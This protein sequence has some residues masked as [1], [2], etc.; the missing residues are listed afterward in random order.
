ML[1]MIKLSERFFQEGSLKLC[2]MAILCLLP[3]SNFAQVDKHSNDKNNNIYIEH[4]DVLSFDEKANP[5]VQVLMGN[6]IFRH[7]SS[8]MYC[9]SA[10]FY[11]KTNSLEAF[12]NVLIEQGDT[13]FI[14]GNY[15]FY[16]GN[17]ELAQMRENVRME[18]NNVTLFTD[19][20]DYDRIANLGYY[21]DG[22]MVVD[23]ENELSSFYG[24]YSPATKDAVFN[25]SV[26]LENP[27]FILYSDTLL[28]NTDSKIA[29]IL[30]PSVIESD[31]ATIYSTKGWYD[32]TNDLSM[33][34]DRSLVVSGDKFLTGDSIFYD[35][36]TGF[37]E[38]FGNMSIR[39]TA[40]KV[41]LEGEYG[42]YNDATGFALA[43]DSACFMEYSQQDTLFLHADTLKMQ[44]IDSLYREMTAYYNVRFYR[45]DLQGVCDSMKFNSKDTV[46]Y[47]YTDPI[48]WNDAYQ[49]Y[50]DTILIYLNDST[51]DFAH[52]KQFA[53]AVQEMDS[54]Y[55][56][57]L[58]GSDLKAYFENSVIER[59]EVAGNAESIFYPLEKDGSKVGLNETKSGFLNIWIKNN[60][61]DLLKI[62]PSPQ[63]VLTPIPDLDPTKKFLKDF[64]WF[65]YLRPVDKDD[66]FKVVRRQTQ[67]APKRSDKFKRNK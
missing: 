57:Q 54:S 18:N 5:D 49:L 20:L 19:N 4:M 41:I 60:K 52:V 51:I 11:E 16:D 61:I 64:F 45:P 36:A 43:T 10:Y 32:T 59:I 2:L 25:D 29:T 47:M 22:G 27:R 50:G 44:T 56:N 62:W 30:G 46:L 28:Y 33:L 34:Y 31:S 39:D 58:K 48:L 26:R 53:F 8:Y 40:Q 14:Y 6:V 13:L 3:V 9:D 7:D 67:D 37:G 15:L 42:Y 1:F 38:A 63:G 55:Y 21:F 12:S 17:T 35:R 65:N 24:K 66:I 23:E